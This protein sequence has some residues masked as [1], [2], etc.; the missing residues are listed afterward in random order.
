[1]TLGRSHL[2]ILEPWFPHLKRGVEGHKS[3]SSKINLFLKFFTFVEQAE[4]PYWILEPGLLA[5]SLT[6]LKSDSE[7]EISAIDSSGL[8]W[9]GSSLMMQ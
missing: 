5:F 1:M 4:R 8:G 9:S 7:K 2:N 6:S 3:L